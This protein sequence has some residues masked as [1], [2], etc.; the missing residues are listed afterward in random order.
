M[1][2]KIQILS[3]ALESVSLYDSGHL[4]EEGAK[5]R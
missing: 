4:Y 1:A 2:L 5:K 3:P